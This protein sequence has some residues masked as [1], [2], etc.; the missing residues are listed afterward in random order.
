ME[1]LDCIV[2]LQCA[3]LSRSVV[4]YA[5]QPHGLQPAKILCPWDSPGQNAGVGCHALF[6]CIFPTQG[7]N[8]VLL[9]LPHRQGVLEHQRYLYH[10]TVWATG[11]LMLLAFS[12]TSILFSIVLYQF[13]FP[14]TLHKGSIFS[15]SFP[16]RVIC[17][18]FDNCPSEKSQVRSH[19]DIGLHPPNN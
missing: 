14:L 2:F 13:T 17:W 18:F 9:H 1:L 5:L 7:L 3:M 11:I 6:Q 4:S 8:P 16:I 15:T 10:F 12:G 19:F